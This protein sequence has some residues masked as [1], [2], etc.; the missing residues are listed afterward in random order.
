M[1]SKWKIALDQGSDFTLSICIK[2]PQKNPID[3]AGYTARMQARKCLSASEVAL[4]LSTDNGLISIDTETST[5]TL[6]IPH[7]TSSAMEATDY[8]YD[9]ELTDAYGKV[10]RCL[11]GV[12]TISPEVTRDDS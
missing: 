4:E 11:Q 1:A 3:L 9:L 12:L 7:D 8:V 5:V 10:W 6:T 2:D